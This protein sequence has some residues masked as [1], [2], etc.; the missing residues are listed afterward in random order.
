M[1]RS[2]W[3]PLATLL[4]AA[5]ALAFYAPRLASEQ[6]QPYSRSRWIAE[7]MRRGV[8]YSG[9]I[10][11]G[12]PTPALEALI[13]Q[14]WEEPKRGGQAGGE[15]PG[16]RNTRVSLDIL[17]PDSSSAAQ[18]ETEAEPYL[19]ADPADAKRLLA[20]YQEDRFADGGGG[21]RALTYAVS[22]DGGGHWREGLLPQLT[23]ASGGAFERAS[24]PWVAF[25]PGHVAYASGLAFDEADPAGG[26]YV[27]TS[28]DGGKTWGAPVAV[29]QQ[30]G[31]TID[32]KDAVVVD[33][34]PHSPFFGRVY[35]GW[36]ISPNDPAQPQVLSIASSLDEGATFGPPVT[37]FA[38]G[39]NLGIL[40]MVGADGT[41]YVVW[42]HFD[43]DN[44]TWIASSYSTDGGNSWS[45]AAKVADVITAPVQSSRTGD[46]LPSAAIDPTTGHLYVVWQD[47]RFTPGTVQVAMTVSADGKG[48]WSAPRRISDGP[49][50][51]ASFTPSVAA[52]AQGQV[53]V[54]WYT[55]R[56]SP[57]GNNL[58][59]DEYLSLGGPRGRPFSR[60]RRQSTTSWDN[61][62]AAIAGGKFFLGDYQGLA[63]TSAGV[64]FPLWV[65]TS[66]PSRIDPPARQ[67]DVYTLAV[68]R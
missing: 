54:G 35:V 33:N 45:P 3:L 9:G 12:G 62:A 7:G 4:T 63:A 64:F 29:H 19:A 44:T 36:D 22:A 37:I 23:A 48:S 56:N 30:D 14:P 41:V 21:A 46:G 38:E 13:A 26:V 24:D 49:N 28:K 2:S 53:A 32:D 58:E 8:H 27:S 68:G 20:F 39:G 47:Q 5:C 50:G 52:S 18:P 60:G 43:A 34:H 59:V 16:P 65:A 10:V 11:P 17:R 25:G 55:F 15:P 61:R 67:P 51:A 1:K 40:P 42:L 66:A 31:N 57:H 6:P